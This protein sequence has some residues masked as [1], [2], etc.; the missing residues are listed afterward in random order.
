MVDS[1]GSADAPSRSDRAPHTF[2]AAA[3]ARTARVGQRGDKGASVSPGYTQTNSGFIEGQANTSVATDI[4][5]GASATNRVSM[6]IDI[7][8][9][10]LRTD[11]HIHPNFSG[12]ELLEKVDQQLAA[13]FKL[14]GNT[15]ITNGQI[16]HQLANLQQQAAGK[17]A[18]AGRKIG[19]DIARLRALQELR[20]LIAEQASMNQRAGKLDA[21]IKNLRNELAR[22]GITDRQWIDG[23]AQLH[24]KAKAFD[25]ILHELAGSPTADRSLAVNDDI[26]LNISDRFANP[27]AN[28]KGKALQHYLHHQLVRMRRELWTYVELTGNT[29][30]AAGYCAFRRRD[31]HD[32]LSDL[33]AKARMNS[34]DP[35]AISQIYGEIDQLDPVKL[36]A[37]NSGKPGLKPRA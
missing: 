32:K 31:L 18:F 36:M 25:E 6:P 30:E 17:N 3:G 2:E 28:L 7:R 33:C 23:R 29:R 37:T 13:I 20:N 8:I 11:L 24:A 14:D 35:D 21:E 34:V 12:D 15:K 9:G 4:P 22:P 16:D 1:T 10:R 26:L 5:R 19:H 27:P